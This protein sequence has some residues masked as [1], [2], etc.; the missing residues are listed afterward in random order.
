MCSK[1]AQVSAESQGGCLR[2]LPIWEIRSTLV[3]EGFVKV[4]VM[5]CLAVSRSMV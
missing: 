5:K 2:R 1:R 3:I 4:A